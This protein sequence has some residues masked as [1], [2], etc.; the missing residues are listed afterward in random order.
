MSEGLKSVVHPAS[1]L[2]EAKAMFS[3]ALNAE[4]VMELQDA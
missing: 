4:P 1:D 3:A 2:A